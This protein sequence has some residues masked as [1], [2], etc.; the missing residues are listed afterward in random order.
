MK[1][2]R[3]T[4]RL[5]GTDKKGPYLAYPRHS[6]FYLYFNIIKFTNNE[7][8]SKVPDKIWKE[9]TCGNLSE[10]ILTFTGPFLNLRI[11]RRVIKKRVDK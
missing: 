5:G 11:M 6:I 3:N 1:Q 4:N 2:A 8:K 9:R 7:Y 10:I